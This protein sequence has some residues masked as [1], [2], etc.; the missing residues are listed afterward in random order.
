MGSRTNYISPFTGKPTRRLHNLIKIEG[1]AFV[2]GCI[3]SPKFPRP[4]KLQIVPHRSGHK[5]YRKIRA[6]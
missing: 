5:R 4:P 1:Y 6:K 2:F 3:E